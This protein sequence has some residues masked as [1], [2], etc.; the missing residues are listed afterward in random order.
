[1]PEEGSET[2]KITFEIS[3]ESRGFFI[4]FLYGRKDGKYFYS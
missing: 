4:L 1:M 2:A 3:L